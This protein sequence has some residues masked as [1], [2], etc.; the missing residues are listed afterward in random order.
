MRGILAG[1][2]ALIVLHAL[3]ARAN[4]EQLAGLTGLAVGLVT[5]IMDPT[6]PAIGDHATYSPPI[7][8]SSSSTSSSKPKY[9]PPTTPAGQPQ[10]RAG[11]NPYG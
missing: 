10:F 3:V 11:A 8:T 5:R 2:L 7:T 6:I 9:P 4:Q 1:A